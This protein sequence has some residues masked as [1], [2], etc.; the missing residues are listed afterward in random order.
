MNFPGDRTNMAAD[1]GSRF[2][3]QADRVRIQ[4][5][6]SES[7]AAFSSDAQTASVRSLI[8]AS[9]GTNP[10]QEIGPS[11]VINSD[12]HVP[13]RRVTLGLEA[14]RQILAANPAAHVIIL[15]RLAMT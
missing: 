13:F 4:W 1:A 8:R 12:G 6:P 2:E 7:L 9:S 15:S 5:W 11:M 10:K 3:N 14:T